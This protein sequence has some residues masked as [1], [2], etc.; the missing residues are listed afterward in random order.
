MVFTFAVAL[1]AFFATAYSSALRAD[2]V[3]SVVPH[4]PYKS[5]DDLT[6]GILKNKIDLA[7]GDSFRIILEQLKKSPKP[8]WKKLN[9][10]LNLRPFVTVSV[11]IFA[12]LT[13]NFLLHWFL[14][15][16]L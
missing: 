3:R 11:K 9:E 6:N 10:A 2:F 12:V 8:A 4:V 13:T 5:L 7:T 15:Y 1:H 14:N 16:S